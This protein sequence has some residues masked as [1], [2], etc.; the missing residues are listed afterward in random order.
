MSAY[1]VDPRK[2]K[3]LKSLEFLALQHHFLAL[4]VIEEGKALMD[5]QTNSK[6][7]SFYI[8][9]Y[10]FRQRLAKSCMVNM[11]SCIRLTM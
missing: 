4:S 8:L 5:R 7:T 9:T 1:Q 2:K 10:Y 6:E 11:V 3:S